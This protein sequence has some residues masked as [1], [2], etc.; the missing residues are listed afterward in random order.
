MPDI[1]MCRGEKDEKICPNRDKCYRYIAN[2]SKWQSYFAT[3]PDF[4]PVCEHFWSRT[5]V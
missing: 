4:E 1:T 5:Q 2:P 3:T